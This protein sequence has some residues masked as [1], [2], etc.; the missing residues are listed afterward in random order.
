M[1]MTATHDGLPEL[2]LC[3]SY[4]KEIAQ[5]LY[6]EEDV[7]TLVADRQKLLAAL[8]AVTKTAADLFDAWENGTPCY[9]D[10][11]EQS[12]Y[13][14]NAFVL[15]DEDACIK[16]INDAEAVLKGESIAADRKR[17]GEA[18]LSEQPNHEEALQLA[19]L[20]QRESNLARCYIDLQSRLMP[21]ATGF[22]TCSQCDGK[23]TWYG[24]VC[25]QCNGIGKTQ[26]APVSA[27]LSDEEIDSFLNDLSKMAE[28]DGGIVYGLPTFNAE[29]VAKAG[30]KLRALTSRLPE[31]WVAVKDRLPPF[32]EDLRVLIYTEGSD[33]AGE[34]FFDVKADHLNDAYWEDE[35]DMPEVC[36]HATH[37]KLLPYPAIAAAPMPKQEG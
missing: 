14:G 16:A 33:F 28:E 11:E 2:P 4:A 15:A 32:G 30:E 21:N 36:R 7:R 8:H 27:G 12:G 37:W 9:E 10:P 5:R 6:K 19:Y 23:G 25:D 18:G 20:K 31:G 34:Q 22:V 35:N 1:T 29:F 3:Y 13:L 26:A 24:E 17:E